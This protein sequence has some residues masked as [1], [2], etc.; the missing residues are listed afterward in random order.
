MRLSLSVFAAAFILSGVAYGADQGVVSTC[1]VTGEKTDPRASC[2]VRLLNPVQVKKATIL[3]GD[4]PL[5]DSTFN[6]FEDGDGKAAW[7]FLIDRSNP[8]RSATVKRSIA[9]VKSLYAQANARNI[10]AVGTFAEDLRVII[11]PGDPYADFDS[12]FASVKADGAATAFYFTAIKAIDILKKVPAERRALVLI[13]DGKAEDTAYSREDVVKHAKEA[14]VVIYG[15]GIAEKRSETV[16]L[17]EVERLA[18]ET[19]GPFVSSVGNQ[20]L[21]AEF[22]ANFTRYLTNGGQITA[23][24]GTLSGEMTIA[25]RLALV[26]GA[27]IEGEKA[28]AFVAPQPAPERAPIKAAPVPPPPEPRPLIAEIYAAFDPILPGSR[29]WAADNETFAWILLLGIPLFIVGI[30]AI[31]VLRNAKQAAKPDIVAVGDGADNHETF[32][33]QPMRADENPSP[34]LAS[35][36]P[37]G[38]FESMDGSDLRFEIRERNITIGRH[39][40]NDFQL[41]DDSVHR[42]HAVFHILPGQ[43]PVI[44]DLDTVNGVVVNGQRVAKAELLSGDVISLGETSFRFVAIEN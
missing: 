38:F 19:D 39:S 32:Y 33:T 43:S 6:S 20:D 44:T 23:P 4:K 40:E 11:S 3:A 26:D 12:R 9:L 14:G 36:E 41:E 5:A 31:L 18:S 7:F 17:Q 25:P 1:T 30:L 16:Y 34:L 29:D 21:P 28:N 42:H 15:I 27:T 10:M 37:F 13:S 2:D 24:L 8:A 35:G 22:I